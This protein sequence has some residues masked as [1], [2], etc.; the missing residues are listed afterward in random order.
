VDAPVAGD[1][2][3]DDAEVELH[4][5]N[6]TPVSRR[7]DTVL[8]QAGP[9][10]ATV[11]K[12]MLH[13]RSA[14]VDGIPE[15][16]GFEFPGREWVGYLEGTVPAYP[17]PAW[18]WHDSVLVQSARWL[19]EWHDA[20]AGFVATRPVWRAPAHEPPDVICHNDF[21]QYNL[22][23][24]VPESGAIG[25]VAS[26]QEPHLVGVI[27]FDT[28]SPG[29]R[30]W[31]LAYLA[32]RLVPYLD[33]PADRA[34]GAERRDERLSILLD[35]YGMEF[36]HVELFRAMSDRLRELAD[37]SE[38]TAEST[39]RAELREHA[40]MYRADATRIEEETTGS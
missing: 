5:G 27:D 16:R 10:T 22:V 28:M 35:A 24:D 21:A 36:E 40:A 1:D 25:G 34:P 15:P 14:G 17:M 4:G 31:D 3:G 29:P 26:V 32:Y 13:A 33:E 18:V 30:V 38:A 8:R 2:V 11:Q 37:F 23:F 9:W 7:G 20:T 6:V 12:V 19:R 39:G